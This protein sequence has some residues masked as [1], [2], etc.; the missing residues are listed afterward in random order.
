MFCFD[1]RATNRCSGS[2]VNVIQRRVLLMQPCEALRRTQWA[3]ILFACG[4]HE[5]YPSASLLAEA[6]VASSRLTGEPL[7]LLYGKSIKEVTLIRNYVSADLVALVEMGHATCD[8]D[9]YKLT[10]QGQQIGRDALIPGCLVS[11]PLFCSF[12]RNQAF[13]QTAAA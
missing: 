9:R 1:Q 2:A 8:K 6:L 11:I 10:A 5:V 7:D 12:R 3:A 13:N 4:S